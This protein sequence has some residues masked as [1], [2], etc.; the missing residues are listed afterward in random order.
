MAIYQ[1]R[2]VI[3][4]AVFGS[5]L[6]AYIGR[7][8][9]AIAIVYMTKDNSQLTTKTS[10]NASQ[11]DV[12]FENDATKMLYK[13]TPLLKDSYYSEPRVAGEEKFDWDEKTTGLI[14]SAFFYGYIIT[15]I[16][17]GVLVNRYGPRLVCSIGLISTGLI[18]L[19]TPIIVVS[20]FGLQGLI[21]TRVLMGLV[22]SGIF[23]CMYSA[24]TRWVPDNERRFVRCKSFYNENVITI[25]VFSTV[26]ALGQVGSSVGSIL[27]SSM[28]GY[29][30]KYYG[31]KYVFYV[32]GII[33]ITYGLLYFLFVTNNPREHYFA[34]KKEVAFIEANISN[35][36][37]K[38]KQAIPF[39]RIFCCFPLWMSICTKYSM[40]L[41]QNTV[42]YKISSYMSLVLRMPI[43]QVGYF[44]SAFAAV[45]G[46]GYFIGGLTSDFMI[47]KQYFKSKTPVRKIHQSIAVFGS[48]AALLLIPLADCNQALFL[49]AIIACEFAYGF[50]SGGENPIAT[51]LSNDF[52]PMLFALGNMFC[53]TAGF[54]P[55]VMGPILDI[56]PN[57]LKH[58]WFYVLYFVAGFNALCGLFFVFFGSAEP[59]DFAGSIVV[60]KSNR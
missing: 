6:T 30:C 29:L 59:I 58:T 14:L 19:L 35:T 53:T 1:L 40:I 50:S 54:A 24:V 7:L 60:K 22:Q 23:A 20:R 16:P 49:F 34:S 11:S 12:C 17:V 9:L 56:D 44:S 57:R 15:Q 21:A 32:S 18:N 47:R 5:I 2:Y 8:N 10:Y 25:Y 31:W 42:I 3:S 51:D 52:G 33:I 41:L 37:A 39:K 46:L 28:T 55:Q 38:E 27:T 48:S 45:N 43:D 36:A 26:I 13:S 4:L